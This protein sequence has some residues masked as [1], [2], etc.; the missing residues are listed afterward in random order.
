MNVDES[1]GVP[2]V[3]NPVV[4]ERAGEIKALVCRV[5]ETE[6]DAVGLEDRFVDDLGADSMKLIE[7]LSHL[8]IEFDVEIDEDELDRLVHLQGVYDV[9]GDVAGA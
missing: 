3:A 8:E 4:R 6:P 5:L 9:L 7:L 1:A 2:A